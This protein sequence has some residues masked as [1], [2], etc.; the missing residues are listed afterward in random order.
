[1][2]NIAFADRDSRKAGLHAW[3]PKRLW[4]LGLAALVVGALG[5]GMATADTPHNPVDI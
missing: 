1:M 2:K 4:S 5:A 3:S